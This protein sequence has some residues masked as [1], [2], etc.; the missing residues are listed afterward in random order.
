MFGLQY[1]EELFGEIPLIFEGVNDTELAISAAQDPMITGIIEKLSIANN[2]ELGM[3][4][5]PSAKKVAVI[6]D[7][8]ITGMAVKREYY[9]YAREYP[10][11]EFTDI[12]ASELTLN[13]LRQ[14]ISMVGK[15]TIL[16]Y[17]LM[18]E[19]ASGKQYSEK[20]SHPFYHE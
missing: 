12:N 13:Q 2:I 14:K 10:E 16:I 5:N 15:N 4:L 9:R 3:K 11:L 7:N 17:V 19:N 18:T 6:L 1:R 20:R 8:S